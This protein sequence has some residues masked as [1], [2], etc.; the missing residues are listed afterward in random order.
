MTVIPNPQLLHV[1]LAEWEN[2]CCGEARHVG[3]TVELRVSESSGEIWEQR[4]ADRGSEVLSTATI[5]GQVMTITLHP[6]PTGSNETPPSTGGHNT[7]FDVTTIRPLGPDDASEW[8]IE[9][10]VLLDEAS[11]NTPIPES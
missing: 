9:F 6:I 2:R 10:T 7:G 1:W 3:Q 11:V 5:R 8:D 4:H